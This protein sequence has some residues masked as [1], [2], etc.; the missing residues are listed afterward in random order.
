LG[1]SEQISVVEVLSLLSDTRSL[2]LFNHIA[3]LEEKVDGALVC[4]ALNL[5]P[6]QYYDRLSRLQRY[7]LVTRKQGIYSI[8]A[9][10]KAIFDAHDLIGIALKTYWKLSA[11]DSLQS[12]GALTK[13]DFIKL[14]NSLSGIEKFRQILSSQFSEGSGQRDDIESPRLPLLQSILLPKMTRTGGRK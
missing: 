1:K 14:L 10:G 12:S 9:F 6:R 11:I 3:S 2:T 4:R 13:S 7:G 8:T 5:T